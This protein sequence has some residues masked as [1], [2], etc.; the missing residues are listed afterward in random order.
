MITTFRIMNGL[1]DEGCGPDLVRNEYTATRGHTEKLYMQQ[2]RTNRRRH[3]FSQ[4]VVEPWNALPSTVI[5][6][7][8]VSSF[9]TRLDIHM[10]AQDLVYNYRKLLDMVK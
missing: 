7:R 4:R 1:C 6:A 8:T 10:E 5:E 9:K 3:S 2:S